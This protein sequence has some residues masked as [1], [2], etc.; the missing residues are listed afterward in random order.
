[1]G[2]DLNIQNRLVLRA[3]FPQEFFFYVKQIISL[4]GG[5]PKT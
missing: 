2:L 5:Y 4:V 3:A 1:M